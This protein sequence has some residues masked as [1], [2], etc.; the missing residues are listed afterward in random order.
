VLVVAR[1][2]DVRESEL[3]TNSDVVSFLTKARRWVGA[4]L[5]L[6]FLTWNAAAQ[7]SF[8]DLNFDS[9]SIAPARSGDDDD[10][11]ASAALP[12]W[13]VNYGSAQQEIIG[14]NRSSDDRANVSLLTSSFR[15][16]AP[17][18]MLHGRYYLLL[19]EGTYGSFQPGDEPLWETVSISQTAE[20]P[21][22]AA[23]LTFDASIA[24]FTVSLD[25]TVLPLDV[26]QACKGYDVYACDV[27]EWAGETAQLKF[28]ADD[29]TVYLDDICFSSS[30]VPEPAA[31]MPFALCAG[32]SWWLCFGRRGRA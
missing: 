11:L 7:K 16:G 28:T 29:P 31:L 26:L 14:Y 21:T 17:Q 24:Q 25:G 12:G 5:L 9:G 15:H 30:P 6:A 19:Q 8:Q 22:T 32:L 1:A 2:R 3:V 27:S 20:V 10:I 23:S 18:G 13:S 4:G